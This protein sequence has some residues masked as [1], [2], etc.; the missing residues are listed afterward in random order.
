MN[1]VEGKIC[2]LCKNNWVRLK[3]DKLAGEKGIEIYICTHTDL[4]VREGDKITVRSTVWAKRK[5]G[6]SFKIDALKSPKK[7]RAKS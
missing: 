2:P 5:I 3:R 1:R 6:T 7:L 4:F